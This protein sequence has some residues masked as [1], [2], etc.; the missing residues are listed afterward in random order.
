MLHRQAD[1]LQAALVSTNR[2][3]LP[4]MCA[5]SKDA[6]EAT[7]LLAKCMQL[8]GSPLQEVLD[9]SFKWV[10]ASALPPPP[11]RARQVHPLLHSLASPAARS[12]GQVTTCWPTPQW[13]ARRRCP[14]T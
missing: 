4:H 8:V 10:D 14:P 11:A 7:T 9:P 2:I 6:R 1:G 3:Y 12:L 13:R 5:L